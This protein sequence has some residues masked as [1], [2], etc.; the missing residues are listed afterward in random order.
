M[1][2]FMVTLYI[3]CTITSHSLC[4]ISCERFWQSRGVCATC[5]LVSLASVVTDSCKATMSNNASRNVPEFATNKIKTPYEII[6]TDPHFKRVVRYARPSDYGVFVAGTAA[7]PAGIYLLERYF[8][9]NLPKGG[10][11]AAMRL[12]TFLGAVGG[13]LFAYQSSSGN[14]F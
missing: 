2:R 14:C 3:G 9:T 11:A 1:A 10:M 13:F 6:D 12:S 7:F 4:E 8:P 5:V